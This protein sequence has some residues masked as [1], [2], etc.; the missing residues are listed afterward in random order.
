MKIRDSVVL[1]SGGASGLGL[2]I[3][4][5]LL[6][7]GAKVCVL[8]KSSDLL[9]KL[10]GIDDKFCVDILDIQAIQNSI[11]VIIQKYKKIDVLINN[12]GLIYSEP[13]LN[14]FKK[15][16]MHDYSSFRKT[17]V[18]NL[19]TVF[20][21]SSI[22]IEQMVAKRT[23]GVIINISSISS[24]GNPGQTAYSAAKA[25]VNA[26]TKTWAKELAP[27]G[28]RCNALSP[29][30]IDTES[31]HQALD[32]AVISNVIKATPLRKLGHPQNV[33]DGVIAL[34]MNDFINGIILDVH[35]GLCI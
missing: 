16:M 25:G 17:I 31:T 26:M 3:V 5:S 11:Q 7:N 30:F 9:N 15:N 18:A 1:V 19:D 20:I 8:D 2:Q 29:G 6:E 4:K 10:D 12:A 22:V 32:Q 13:M 27:L 33:A 21:L 23:N 28:I 34:I 35:G 24:C 14:L